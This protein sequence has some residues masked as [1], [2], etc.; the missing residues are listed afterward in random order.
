LFLS[1][2]LTFLMTLFLVAR[3][4]GFPNDSATSL[5]TQDVI[6]EVALNVETLRA[7]VYKLELTLSDD[8]LHVDGT[9]NVFVT[10]S[11][12]EPWD[13]LVF[14]L[15]PN[16]LGST[17]VV[18]ETLVD[19]VAVTPVLEVSDTVF[20]VPVTLQPNEYVVV[21]LTYTV[22]LSSEIR[23]YGRLAKFQ[24]V[25]SLS[26]A[27]PTLSV[28]ETGSVYQKGAW[29]H[30][31]PSEL[32][33]PLVAETS[34]FD[35]MIDAPTDWQLIT[36][37]MKMVEEKLE[38]T[39]RQRV[40]I[41]T[42]PVRDFYIAAT[43]GYQETTKQVGETTVRVFAPQKFSQT[44]TSALETTVQAL[45]FFS[46]FYTPYPYREFDLV[47]IPVEAGGIEYP[48]I[49]V[50]ANGLF[51]NPFGRFGSVL[52]HETAHQW[53]FNLVGSNQVKNPWL[54]ESLTQYLTW[55]FQ[56]EVSPRFITGLENYWQNLWDTAPNPDM[57][58]GLPVSAY[59]EASY[60]G[61]VYG[62]GLFF[63]KALVGEMGQERFDDALRSYF[64]TYAWRFATPADFEGALERSCACEL[65]N[66]F[67]EWVR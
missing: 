32:G 2:F 4:E 20:R 15:Y 16:A 7:P 51:A 45:N 22:T 9:A 40:H 66:L 8:L 46:K 25:L 35:V 24:D 42:G 50:V 61:I 33:D 62:K 37:G 49:I 1:F 38:S 59:D 43:L 53:S 54:D 17:M 44:A 18:S 13:E 31:Y 19:D 6:S 65:S 29:L 41:V 60:G 56:K 14:R 48:G 10:N 26:H 39:N 11:S 12:A 5:F 27:Y 67:D 3:A 57:P 34:L 55:R 47:A 64:E 36:T 58:I 30:D 21:K 28:Y 52:A 63:F 23:S